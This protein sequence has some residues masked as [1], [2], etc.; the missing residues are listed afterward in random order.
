MNNY[1]TVLLEKHIKRFICSKFVDNNNEVDN[2]E[3]RYITLP[4]LGHF[5]YQLRNTMSNLLK[6]HIQEVKFKFI[7]V[8][9]N[10]IGSLFRVK[11]TIPNSLLFKRS[12]LFQMS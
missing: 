10:T 11:D 4:Y 1:P 9:R 5:S 2:R 3:T 6:K 7:F 12:L 8:N